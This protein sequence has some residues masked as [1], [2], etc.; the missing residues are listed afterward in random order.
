MAIGDLREA[1]AALAPG[2][3]ISE[4]GSAVVLFSVGS[5]LS[6]PCRAFKSVF[7]EIAQGQDNEQYEVVDVETERSIAALF[8][9]VV[10]SLL[11]YKDGVPVCCFLGTRW[12][13]E[14]VLLWIRDCRNSGA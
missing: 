11:F 9:G 5:G 4:R 1:Y 14:D 13:T 7:D 12:A 6:S 8:D 10:P 3:V 2:A